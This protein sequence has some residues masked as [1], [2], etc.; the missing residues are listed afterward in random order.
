MA[1]ATR[2]DV[3]VNTLWASSCGEG[4]EAVGWS[5]DAPGACHEPSLEI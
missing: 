5:W 2:G 4:A 3:V 1:Q